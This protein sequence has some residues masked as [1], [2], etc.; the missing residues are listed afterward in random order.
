LL[1]L[2]AATV[3]AENAAVKLPDGGSTSLSYPLSLATIVLLGPTSGA[4]VAALSGLNA[5]D[6]K[7]RRPATVLAFNVAQVGLSAL[8][9]GWMYVWVGGRVLSSQV[10]GRVATVP[11]RES[12]F[13]GFIAGVFVLAVSSFAVNA[14]LM[15]VGVSMAQGVRPRD[16]WAAVVR[17][18][19]PVQMALS[20]VG[21]VMAQVVAVSAFGFLLLV[22]PL[23]V[24]R[25]LYQRYAGLK[26]AY[27]DTV[28]SLVAAI[29]AKDPYTHGHSERVADYA[30]RIGMSMALD[31]PT[32]EKLRFAAQ[33]HDLGKVGLSRS[34]L[35]KSGVLT[36]S[37]FQDIRRHPQLGASLVQRIPYMSDISTEILHHH[38]RYDGQ[39]YGTGLGGGEIPLGARIIAVADSYDAMTSR[40]P[41]REAM[42]QRQAAAE[43]LAN[44]GTQ[45]DPAVVGHMLRLLDT[46]GQHELVSDHD[47]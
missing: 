30:T 34:L 11:L 29:E 44:S 13:P 47:D 6:I 35:Y 3:V 10:G 19:L 37:E 5:D 27:L 14:L 46:R 7:Q 31:N 39:G 26:E 21:V 22:F 33:L 28:R 42:T 38:E 24:S 8:T 15:G 23:V 25:Q 1:L 45:F 2:A 16:I 43:L 4:L 32:L 17:W 18:M 12:D 36:A 20:L 40:R 41:Y 9:A